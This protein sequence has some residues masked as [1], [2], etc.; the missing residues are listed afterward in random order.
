MNQE[1]TISVAWT[2][3]H[4]RINDDILPSKEERR[5]PRIEGIR[6]FGKEK[7]VIGPVKMLTSAGTIKVNTYPADVMCYSDLGGYQV[8]EDQLPRL[9][10][11]AR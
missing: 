10:N 7:G 2:I 3:T 9:L 1:S 11:S 8:V 5:S 4:C 6:D